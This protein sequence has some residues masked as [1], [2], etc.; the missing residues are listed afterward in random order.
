M[1]S[2]MSS[3]RR[4]WPFLVAIGCGVGRGPC[5]GSAAQFTFGVGSC[6]AA[7]GAGMFATTIMSIVNRHDGNA[8]VQ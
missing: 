5:F 1:M 2:V 7:P 8:R 3:R 6:I 4:T